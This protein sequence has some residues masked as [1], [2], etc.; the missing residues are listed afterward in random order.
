MRPVRIAQI[1]INQYS[2][3]VDIF[4]T[5]KSLPHLFDLPCYCLV[6]DERE[7][8]GERIQAEYAGVPERTLEEILSDPAIE[9]VTV[10]TDEPHLLRYANMAAKAGKHIH[11]EKPGSASLADF[12]SLVSTVK[13]NGTVLHLGYMYR[14]HP[15]VKEALERKKRGEYGHIF[16]VEAHMSREDGEEARRFL[17]SLPDGMMFYLGCHLLDLILQFQGAPSE[18]I[19]LST[20][21]GK[22]GIPSKD[23]GAAVLRYPHGLSFLRAAATELL[24]GD[25]RQLVILGEKRVTEIRPLEI[26]CPT[27]GERYLFESEKR[28]VWTE[29]DGRRCETFRSAPFHRYCAM[30]EAFAAMVRGK[31]KNPNTPDYELTLFKTL[32][33]CCG[34]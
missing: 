9:A 28:E 7:R 27:E 31:K 24:G 2:H 12:E 5:L 14:Y 11:M 4:H 26:Y 6:E 20:A 1:G 3:G 16:S 32:L 22:D 34:V 10:E 18:V 19:P 23:L 30:M 25:R 17:G 33:Q 13:K 15:F 21:T 29:G 8:M